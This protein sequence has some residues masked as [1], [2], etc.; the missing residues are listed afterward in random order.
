[1]SL[2]KIRRVFEFEGGGFTPHSMVSL[3][4]DGLLC[5]LDRE[6]KIR[7]FDAALGKPIKTAGE[8]SSEH[9]NYKPM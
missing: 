8:L 2:L 5:V 3:P 7:L 1:M 6:G 4:D 9:Y